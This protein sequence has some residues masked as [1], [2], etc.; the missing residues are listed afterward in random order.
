MKREGRKQEAFTGNRKGG[1]EEVG[2]GWLK[3]RGEGKMVGDYSA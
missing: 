3:R 2:M 1:I